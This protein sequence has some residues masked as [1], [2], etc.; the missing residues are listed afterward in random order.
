MDFIFNHTEKV[1]DTII[2]ELEDL[3]FLFTYIMDEKS[4]EIV[5]N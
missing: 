5:Q 3:N 1:I 4:V 2:I